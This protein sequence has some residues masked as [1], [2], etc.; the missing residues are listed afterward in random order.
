MERTAERC[1]PGRGSTR[2]DP[3]APGSDGGEVRPSQLRVCAPPPDDSVSAA[4]C[5]ASAGSKSPSLGS[6]SMEALH[7]TGGGD[8]GRW[9]GAAKGSGSLNEQIVVALA[10]L[11]DDMQSVLER[12][13]TLEALT[14]SQVR[15]ASSQQTLTRLKDI[16]GLWTFHSNI[17]AS[18]CFYVDFW[19][20]YVS[21]LDCC[22]QGQCPCLRLVFLPPLRGRIGY[23][24]WF[25][26]Y[27]FV[28]SSVPVTV[29][30]LP[31]LSA[32]VLVAFRHFSTHLCLRPRVAV[33]G[34]VVN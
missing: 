22:R 30:T 18:N 17:H 7:G 33:R 24:C 28:F 2:M 14:A 19:M 26:F 8:G 23:R 12:L 34:A 25:S 20:F 15:P 31:D 6:G 29:L 5:G 3:A 11:Q 10:R 1:L 4:F 13:H 27:I 9:G 16:S 21:F 32:A